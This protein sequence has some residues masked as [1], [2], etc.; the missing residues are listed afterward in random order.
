[1]SLTTNLVSY[2]KCDESGTSNALDAV[3]SNPGVSQGG[4][5]HGSGII[6]NGLVCALSG[7]KYFKISDTGLPIGAGARSISC[8]VNFSSLPTGGSNAIFFNYGT[9]G[10]HE[11]INF[12]ISESSGSMLPIIDDFGHA[13]TGT[14]LSLSL[15]TWYHFVMTWDGSGGYLIYKN[16]SLNQTVAL[17]TTSPNTVLGGIGGLGGRGDGN[18]QQI[19]GTI[20][21]IGI[22]SRV[23]TSAEVTTL[24]NGGAGLQYPFITGSSGFF[25][26]L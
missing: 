20:D 26:L 18:N 16:G 24:Y 22:W 6:G 23:L 7:N 10:V 13:T 14:N 25:H 1:M 5:T 9:A 19:T 8:W 15:S 17:G 12:G 4:A 11:E 3:G 21:E 2:W